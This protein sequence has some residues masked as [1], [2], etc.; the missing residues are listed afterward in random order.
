VDSG[1]VEGD[2]IGVNYDPLIAKLIAFA[3]TRD[4][5]LARAA[6]ALRSFAILGIRTNVPFVLRLLE[7]P[8][9]ASGA[10]HTGLIAAHHAT[11]TAAVSPPLEAVA[12]AGLGQ[13]VGTANAAAASGDRA[14]SAGPDP[15]NTLRGWGR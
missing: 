13:P 3:E 10:V 5:A 7:H 11:L 4:A 9:V 15:W 12:A 8:D 6:A 2:E 1:V 14:G